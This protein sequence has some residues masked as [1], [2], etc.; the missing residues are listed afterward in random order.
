[1]L[2]TCCGLCSLIHSKP[3]YCREGYC[4]E[5]ECI[6]K[7]NVNNPQ[8]Q[9]LCSTVTDLTGANEEMIDT[10]REDSGSGGLCVPMETHQLLETQCVYRVQP[11]E[12]AGSLTS[13]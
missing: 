1:M 11:N 13:I 3:V 8:C 4:R 5:E 6:I 12:D 7:G 9:D 10:C 2:L